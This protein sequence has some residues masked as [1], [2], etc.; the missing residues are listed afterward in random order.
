[1]IA[2]QIRLRDTGG[3]IIVDFIDMEQDENK[4]KVLE[5]LTTEVKKDRTR[6]T[7]VDMTELGLVEI[8]RKRISQDLDNV[9]KEVCPYCKGEGKILS[10]KSLSI[11]IEREIKKQAIESYGEAVKVKLHP[12]IALILIGWDGERIQCLEEVIDKTIYVYIDESQHIKKHQIQF[13]SLDK[14]KKDFPLMEE[15]ELLEVEVKVNH[16]LN[17]QNG[18]TWVNGHIIEILGGGNLVGKRIKVRI[19]AISQHFS[20]AELS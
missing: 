6:T 18:I 17:F 14:I 4:K 19:M 16:P 15:G 2:R 5:K 11:K 9:L 20:K 10:H 1:M 8:T 12:Q 7:V 13:G 3:I